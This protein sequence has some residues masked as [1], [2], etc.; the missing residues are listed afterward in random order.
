MRLCHLICFLI[1]FNVC[2]SDDCLPEEVGKVP[3]QS[4]SEKYTLYINAT[5][6]KY[7]FIF[8][9]FVFVRHTRDDPKFSDR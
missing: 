8:T 7:K 5:A 1:Y 4:L 2:F 9:R 6:A 3:C